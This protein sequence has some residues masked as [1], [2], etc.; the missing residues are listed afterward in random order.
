MI[1]NNKVFHLFKFE[2]N[3]LFFLLSVFQSGAGQAISGVALV[4]LVNE[5]THSTSAMALTLLFKYSPYFIVPFFSAYL[6][7][8]SS[9]TI[10]IL[11][12]I[13]AGSLLT[14]LFSLHY[15]HYAS[16]SIIYICAFITG[17]MAAIYSPV[18]QKFLPRLVD[19]SKIFII[20]VR[21]NQI[22]QIITIASLVV[23]GV[24]INQFGPAMTILIEGGLYLFSAVLLVLVKAK[25]MI[26]CEKVAI[27]N[28]FKMALSYLINNKKILCLFYMILPLT[29]LIAP[30][31]VILPAHLLKLGLGA[32][33]Y[34]ILLSGFMIGMILGG[35]L[36][37]NL[38]Y[39]MSIY[40][41]WSWGTCS[42]VATF[43]LFTWLPSFIPTT[44]LISF[45]GVTIAVLN[46]A[47]LNV[48]QKEI[49]YEFKGRVFSVVFSLIQAISACSLALTAILVKF[50]DYTQVIWMFLVLFCFL[51]CF[52]IK[53]VKKSFISQLKLP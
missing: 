52:S 37:K 19:E 43:L 53:V 39:K 34:T 15:L 21:I 35:Q 48:L 49:V 1:K 2:L 9:K 38:L 27:F 17:S 23:S 36:Y 46:T 14:L 40:S 26:I 11:N 44:F 10:L 31:Q 32:N 7:R 3:I 50:L 13:V 30:F 4:Y 20:N 24:L 22:S 45:F 33:Y 25:P 29:F 18:I 12:N 5:L 8:F 28:G 42:I 41:L 6:D 47:V 16:A 51:V